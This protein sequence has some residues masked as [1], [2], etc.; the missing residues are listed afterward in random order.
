MAPVRSRWA[1]YPT[2]LSDVILKILGLHAE[3]RRPCAAPS[4]ITSRRGCDVTKADVGGWSA[5]SAR[6]HGAKA[7]RFSPRRVC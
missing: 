3:V 5:R 1:E 6:A 7:T 4:A 2:F